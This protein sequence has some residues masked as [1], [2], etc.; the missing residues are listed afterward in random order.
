MGA[1]KEQREAPS[2]GVQSL[3]HT[4]CSWNV[5]ASLS[6]VQ[7][8]G[9][10]AP[11]PPSARLLQGEGEQK[12]SPG[13]PQPGDV[14]VPEAISS[15]VAPTESCH[16]RPGGAGSCPDAGAACPVASP[17]GPVT[18]KATRQMAAE[19][20][21]SVGREGRPACHQPSSHAAVH[22]VGPGAAP[23]APRPE[24][25]SIA[26][27]ATTRSGLSQRL[28]AGG[29]SLPSALTSVVFISVFS[30][31]HCAEPRV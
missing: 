18:G 2:L 12:L 17:G 1:G 16:H 30:L 10:S 28:P 27:N 26:T 3:S 5:T 4:K 21:H 15:S 8:M 23:A 6:R 22:G 25:Q 14:G 20:C 31:S 9:G 11:L 19:K 7:R 24:D 29:S 13:S